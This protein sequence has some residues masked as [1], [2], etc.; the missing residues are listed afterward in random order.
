[1]RAKEGKHCKVKAKDQLCKIT[2]HGRSPL[3]PNM[4]IQPPGPNLQQPDAPPPAAPNHG[5]Q[6]ILQP[7]NLQ[8]PLQPQ[9]PLLV[10][11]QLNE[12]AERARAHFRADNVQAPAPN[13]RQHKRTYTAEEWAAWQQESNTKQRPEE[14]GQ[15]AQRGDPRPRPRSTSRAS[16]FSIEQRLAHLE[17]ITVELKK[18]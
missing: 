16:K 2:T 10:Q 15:R 1:M 11:Q 8:H 14:R 4:P 12:I 7:M 6:Q 3:Q 9:L 17:K 13:P 18:K 5:Q